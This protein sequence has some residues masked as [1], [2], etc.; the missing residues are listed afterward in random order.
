[1]TL[2]LISICCFGYLFTF[3]QKN[4]NFNV[5]SAFFFVVVFIIVNGF[6]DINL[7]EDS[8]N[9]FNNY[10]LS[11]H[12]FNNITEL[13]LSRDPG[14]KFIN[15]IIY[16]FGS[17]W[18]YYAFIM[19]FIFLFLLIKINNL[20]NNN[21]YIF[22]VLIILCPIF[23]ENTSN[24]IR[25]TIC[26]LLMF[27]GF[28]NL[29]KNKKYGLFIILFG[30]S[31][32]YFQG[33]II[34]MIFFCARLNFIKTKKTLNIFV[35]TIFIFLILKNYFLLINYENLLV[36]FEVLNT[37]STDNNV[38]AYTL[39]QVIG[40]KDKITT[41]LLLQFLLYLLIPLYLIDFES[42]SSNK[43]QIVNFIVISLILYVL[44]F[45][46]LI[47]ALRLIPI[48]LIA[49]TYLFTLKDNRIKII[50]SYTILLF[51]IFI[52]LYN[53]TSNVK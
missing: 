8:I 31:N 47:F 12:D 4:N 1:M 42:L 45:P 9:Y 18:Y 13:L 30:I 16:F 36:K 41:N 50:Y 40:S 2:I 29:D 6:R 10:F 20:N 33:L 14:F 15:Y 24:I 43:K 34:L 37:L 5:V 38:T 27:Y 3:L 35:Y 28:L 39:N 32:H 53:F 7:G 17:G 23:F 21:S 52:T 19:S 48:N 25:S 49:V 46:R 11:A 22:L 26:S 44:L 51:N